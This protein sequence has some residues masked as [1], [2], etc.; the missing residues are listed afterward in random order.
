MIRIRERQT[1]L[2]LTLF[3]IFN[4]AL[5][6]AVI[7]LAAITNN[8]F[9]WIIAIIIDILIAYLVYSTLKGLIKPKEILK[10]LGKTLVYSEK[11]QK[12]NEN[13]TDIQTKQKEE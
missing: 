4:L 3:V 9:F 6:T 10:P 1:P 13:T 2:F 8:S 12:F 7:W 11:Q 5:I